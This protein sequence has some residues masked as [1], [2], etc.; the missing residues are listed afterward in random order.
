LKSRWFDLE[1]R[2]L[3]VAIGVAALAIS[4]L[5]FG[6]HFS[7]TEDVSLLAILGIFMANAIVA[8]RFAAA[9]TSLSCLC[10]GVLCWANRSPGSSI[11]AN[12]FHSFLL[13][14]FGLG[15]VV[16]AFAAIR[17]IFA[18]RRTATRLTI[19]TLNDNSPQL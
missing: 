4:R 17:A 3:I 6:F 7:E 18:P 10:F 9:G 16:Y 12:G 5:A 19:P 15:F 14:F 2:V 11:L 13:T 8:G 1:S